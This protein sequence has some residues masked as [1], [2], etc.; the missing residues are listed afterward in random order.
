MAD[1]KRK[2][3]NSVVLIPGGLTPVLQSRDRMLNKQMKR[4]LR[5]K[6]IASTATAKKADPKTGKLKAPWCGAVSTWCKEAWASITPDLVK[7][8]FK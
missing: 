5:A 4:L 7:T 8:C 2:T 3:N 1:L 6:D